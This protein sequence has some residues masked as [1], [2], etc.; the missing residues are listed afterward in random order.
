MYLLNY[1]IQHHYETDQNKTPF[2]FTDTISKMGQDYTFL[3]N[4]T[5]ILHW[6]EFSK[7]NCCFATWRINFCGGPRNRPFSWCHFRRQ[8][9]A[10][11]RL[12][13]DHTL[14]PCSRSL[15]IFCNRKKPFKV[16]VTQLKTHLQE[17]ECQYN[18][19]LI[20]LVAY[21]CRQSLQFADIQ[22]IAKYYTVHI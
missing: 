21:T 6:C 9:V 5:V 12:L 2:Y 19:L 4:C 16:L 3:D 10:K 1:V 18:P 8:S 14:L 15:F 22:N 11:A 20:K 13:P 17:H 7:I